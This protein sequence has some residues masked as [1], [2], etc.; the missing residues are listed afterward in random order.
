MGRGLGRQIASH[1]EDL[2][3]E[4]GAERIEVGIFEYNEPSMR[5][6]KARGYQEFSRR[7]H[8]AWWNGRLWD[9]VRL[10]KPLGVNEP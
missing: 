10:L 7:P 1:L 9:D 8:R 6:F 3:V 2:A 4:A 5:F